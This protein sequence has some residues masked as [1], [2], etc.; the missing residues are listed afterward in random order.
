MTLDELIALLESMPQ[1]R[2]FRVGL[3]EPHSWRGIYAELAFEPARD[4]TVAA[5][6]KDA[7]SALGRT[8]EG[9][10]G[11]DFR[12]DGYSE[13]HLSFYGESEDYWALMALDPD[14]P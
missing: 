2:V 14:S 5:M 10:K 7:R 6:L 11:G 1:D 9:Y 4:V 3:T 12:M 13:V 8:F